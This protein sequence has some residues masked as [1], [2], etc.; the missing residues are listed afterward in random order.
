[1]SLDRRHFLAACTSLGLSSTLLP[2]VLYAAA[3][4]AEAKRITPEM[5]DDA[6]ILAGVP[7]A[8]DQKA[9]MLSILNQNRK[10]FDELRALN[11]PNSVSPAF[12]F[13]PLPPGQEPTP[14]PPGADLRKP[15]KLSPASSKEVPRDL[16]Q[17]AFYTVRD[18]G[19]LIRRKKVSSLDLT[20]MY[21]G[22]MKKYDPQL[23]CV[24]TITEERALA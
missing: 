17:L 6:A 4:E 14:P 24:I 8:P 7:I 19:D 10:G 22:R 3:T 13:N 18:L 12:I 11:M 21:I 16:N 20:Q 15:L 9:A 1:M 5:I 23:H 2:G